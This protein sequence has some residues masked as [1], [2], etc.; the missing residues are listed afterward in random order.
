MGRDNPVAIHIRQ[1]RAPIRQWMQ[2]VTATL[3][4]AVWISLP[5]SCEG[6]PTRRHPVERQKSGPQTPRI[7]GPIERIHV[8]HGTHGFCRS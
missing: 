4:V 8:V 1:Y 3:A 7:P 5:V 2:R 6:S